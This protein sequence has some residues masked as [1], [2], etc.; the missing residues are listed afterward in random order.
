LL[1]IT[2]YEKKRFYKE[3][4]HNNNG[5]FAHSFVFESKHVFSQI[6]VDEEKISGYSVIRWK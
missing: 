3:K 6:D 4:R 2:D 5:E 1:K